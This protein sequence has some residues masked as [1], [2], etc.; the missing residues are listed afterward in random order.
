MFKEQQDGQ[1]GLSEQ[2]KMEG[3]CQHFCLLQSLCQS[4]LLFIKAISVPVCCAEAELPGIWVVQLVTHLPLAWVMTPG[5]GMEPYIGFPAQWGACF[6]L[7][8]PLVMLS[9]SFSL[10]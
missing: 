10:K 6:S 8:L 9:H 3:G 1:C 4:C 2:R 5:P 7:S